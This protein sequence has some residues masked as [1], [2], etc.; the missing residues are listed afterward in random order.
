MLDG[1]Y[2]GSVVYGYFGSPCSLGTIPLHEL[3]TGMLASSQTFVWAI[4]TTRRKD[5]DCTERED[6][7]CS[8]NMVVKRA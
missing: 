4:P 8:H 2:E 3:A 7:A 6:R 1:Q 5:N